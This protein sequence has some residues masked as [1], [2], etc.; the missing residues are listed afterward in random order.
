[1]KKIIIVLLGVA[2]VLNLVLVIGMLGECYSP[3]QVFY[4]I[5]DEMMNSAYRFKRGWQLKNIL[6]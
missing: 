3:R 4:T 6:P 2:F 5:T 1:M